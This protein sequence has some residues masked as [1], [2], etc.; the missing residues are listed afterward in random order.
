M[1]YTWSQDKQQYQNEHG[2]VLGRHPPQNTPATTPVTS[3]AVTVSGA[4]TAVSAWVTAAIIGV[5]FLIQVANA[6]RG[7]AWN[8]QLGLYAG[9]PGFLHALTAPLLHASFGHLLGNVMVLAVFGFLALHRAGV[10][11][12]LWLTAAAVVLSAGFFW[13]LAPAGTY[14]VGASG[15]IFAYFTY[16]LVRGLYEHCARDIQVSVFAGIV[17]F[18]MLSGLMPQ[19]GIAWE[20]HLGGAVAGAACAWYQHRAHA[21][22]QALPPGPGPRPGTPGHPLRCQCTGCL[23]HQPV[24]PSP[25][26]RPAGQFH[27]N[28]ERKAY[29]TADGRTMADVAQGR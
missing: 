22:P 3:P 16:V 23:S 26:P 7:Y 25:V 20:A 27:W 12:F 2:Q 4:S 24:P 13:V 11:L 15:V 18:G 10:Q 29:V 14:L 1:P 21:T 6:A 9:Q 8:A 5:L 28:Q 19:P 17:F